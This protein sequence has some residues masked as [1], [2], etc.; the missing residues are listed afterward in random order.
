M[1]ATERGVTVGLDKK[2]PEKKT[3]PEVNSLAV[4]PF[5][6]GSDDPNAE[7]LSDGLTESIINSLSH[8]QNFR[9]MARNTV[10]RYKPKE[11]DPQVIGQELGVDSVLT[12]RILQLGDR[13][14][15]RAEMVSVETGWHMWGEQY[16]RKLSDILKVQQEISEEISTTLKRKLTRE[17]KRRVT[18]CYTENVDA[19]RA[20]LRGRY[21]WNKFDR[22]ALKKAVDYFFQ[23][24]EIDPAYALA[25]AGLADSYYRLSNVYAP[26]RDAMSKAKAA[27]IKALDIDETLSEAHAA[28]GLIKLFYDWDW[29]GAEEE[30]NR[31]I[32][33]NPNNAIAHQR[34]GLYFNLLGRFAEA[35][36]E[37]ELALTIDPLSP[38]I[39][40][41]FALTFLLARDYQRAI[42]ELQKT[43]E[44]DGNYKPALYLLGRVYEEAGQVS[45]AIAE[46][47]RILALSDA[48]M[49]LAALGHAYALSGKHREAR[50]VLKDLQEQSKQ[51]YV[52]AYSKAVI[53]LTLGN[54]SQGFACL[55][56]AYEDRCEMMT[57]LK[58][59]P[60]F[61]SVR[62][63]IRFSNLMRRVGLN[64]DQL[65]CQK[66]AAS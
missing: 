9:V 18:T 54:K 12:G 29:L 57:W 42:E 27:A 31:A 22:T 40:W 46:F 63:D 11:V 59:D 43:L 48:P 61:D 45:Q 44:M 7:Y 64:N 25:Y 49:F 62:A 39:Y 41:G 10:F 8:L 17:E 37:L 19:Y 35:R 21:H 32:E 47:K 3:D 50:K 66:Y 23:A 38:Q 15:V 36:R 6:N 58:I 30:F 24:I 28:L 16:H 26:T 52:S 51:Q 1:E 53:H 56:Q 34:L 33:S 14:I 4:L 55:E 65:V 2:R 13:I 5:D 20:Y 60:A